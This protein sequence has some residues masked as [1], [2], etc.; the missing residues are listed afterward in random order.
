MTEPKD[1]SFGKLDYYARLILYFLAKTS[2][3]VNQRQLAEQVGIVPSTLKPRLDMLS[4]RSLI[5]IIPKGNK[6]LII[7]SEEGKDEMTNWQKTI[8]GTRLAKE[9]DERLKNQ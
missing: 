2:E 5:S 4:S 6:N 9:F 1:A 7:I 8:V 3:N